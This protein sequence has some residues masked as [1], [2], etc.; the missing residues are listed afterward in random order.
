MRKAAFWLA[1]LSAILCLCVGVAAQEIQPTNIR[2]LVN[3]DGV[4]VRLIPALGA[5]VI[6]FVNAGYT[7]NV[8][9]RSPDN[10]WVRVRFSGEEGW[11]GMAVLTI[12]EGDL[13]SA[14]VEDPRTIPYGGW[15]SPRAGLTSATGAIT[16]RLDD[17]GVR[18]RSGPSR[19][20]AFLV[21]APRRSVLPLLGRTYNNAWFQVNYQGTLGWVTAQGVTIQGA[22]DINSLPIDGI[23]AESVPPSQE[24][25]ED[26]FG[27]LRLMRDRVN[28][29]QPSL[30]QIRAIWT[31]VALGN[32][33][34]CGSYP[35]RPTPYNI[36][37]P[38]LAGYYDILN[39]LQ[40]Q[41]ND[42]MTNVRN[43]IDLL[44]DICNR[45]QPERGSVGQAVVQG[46]LDIVNVAD[47]QFQ[48]LR[49][50]LNELIPPDRQPGPNECAFTYRIATEIIPKLEQN[51]IYIDH[52]T[53]R[54]TITGFCFDAVA[55]QSLNVNVM[56]LSGNI[57]IF[58]AVS[59]FDNPTNFVALARQSGT[60]TN[61]VT[62][63]PVNIPADGR[64][65]VIV[66]DIGGEGGAPREDPPGGDFAILVSAPLSGIVV[67]PAQTI[68]LATGAFPTTAYNLTPIIPLTQLQP[69][70]TPGAATA[71][72]G[73]ATGGTSFC[74]GFNLTCQQLTCDQARAC[75]AAGN[76]SLDPDNNGVPCSC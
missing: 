55:G 12:L 66:T 64:Y 49:G 25:A 2:V 41:F 54:R 58:I 16:G 40:I 9:A 17:S 18:V 74:P 5:E 59:P 48:N 50:R 71:T 65:L 70:V 22:F 42:A 34:Q 23:V 32:T 61:L 10:E 30:D 31:D 75:L 27:T 35:A 51:R 13:N 39:P 67:D 62:A 63:G 29:A 56:R 68:D 15:G 60:D 38:L 6:G 46:A 69:V 73:G 4:N 53:A 1:M 20:Y 76:F 19:A 26:Y 52:I 43:S 11:I 47:A 72:P 21:N 45:P 8:Y 36:P 44:I 37:N 28:L 14:P 57:G 33:V 7:A 24:T 3:R